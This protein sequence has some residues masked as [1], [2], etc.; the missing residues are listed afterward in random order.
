MHDLQTRTLPR[1]MVDAIHCLWL[2]HDQLHDD[3]R[4]ATRHTIIGL[5]NTDMTDTDQAGSV[6]RDT[7]PH[8]IAVERSLEVLNRPHAAKR[9][10]KI[11]RRVHFLT[12]PDAV[13]DGALARLG[14]PP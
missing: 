4:A 12:L 14:G 1:L 11:R 6:L 7:A 5:R 10:R 13:R 3:L 2:A 8:L 9:V